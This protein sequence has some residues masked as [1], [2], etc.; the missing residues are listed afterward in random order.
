MKKI[1]LLA[2][3]GDFETLKVAVQAGANAVYLAGKQ[4]GARS[5]SPNFT[6]EELKEA[7]IYAHLRRVKIYITVNTIVYQEEW[8]TLIEYV[9]FLYE[10]GV[11]ALI[12]Q[13]LGVLRYIRSHY[14]DF[15]VHA[16]TQ[17]NIYDPKGAQFLKNVGVKRVVLAREASLE[18]V[19]A[20]VQTGIEVE[21]FVHGAL[22]FASSGNC[23]MSYTIG[24]RSGNRGQCAQPCRKR[25][26][27]LENSH[28]I[29][30]KM[31]LLSMK[32]LNTL[33][34]LKELIQSGACSFKIEGRMK[35]KAYVYCV[36]KNY[37]QALD[38][39]ETGTYDDFSQK[40]STDLYTVFNRQF[41]KGYLLYENNAQLTNVVDVNHQGSYLGK[42]TR[43]RPNEIDILLS[44][45]L[46]VK[47]A[48]RIKGK[49]EVGFILST[50]YVNQEKREIAYPG[51]T[52]RIQMAHK[53]KVGSQVVKTQSSL[54]QQELETQIKEEPIRFPVDAHLFIRLQ[55][56]IS[57]KLS[58]GIHQVIVQGETI[59]ERA[60]QPIAE[61][62]LL[63]KLDKMK[64]TPFVL[65]HCTIDYDQVAFI[66][67]KELNAIRRKATDALNRTILTTQLKVVEPYFEP[68]LDDISHHIQIEAVVHTQEQAKIC[69]TWGITTIYTDYE[70]EHQNY[71]RLH[72]V[73][74]A[75]GLIH[76][77][78]QLA[79][80]KVVSPYLNVVN[81]EAVCF[82]AHF[83][84]RCVYLS[85][86][87]SVDQVCQFQVDQLPIDIGVMIYGRMDVMATQHCMISKIKGY[88]KKQCGACR[89]Q[90]ALADEYGN[91]FPILPDKRHGCSLRILDCHIRNWLR[92]QKKLKLHG[93]HCFLLVF[94]IE[95]EAEVK[96]VLN[97][98]NR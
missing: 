96:Q 15:E 60:K 79:S 76:N 55:Y 40:E 92:Y 28:A 59:E 39:I 88:E 7:I 56:P 86:E 73:Q 49:E 87:L 61:S 66:S 65:R 52:V 33:S 53:Q 6:E 14:P 16:S 20:I 10:I 3:A 13:D 26:T 35:S 74:D 54:L 2:P 9:S 57:L 11:D 24:G 30:K 51:E 93:I 97:Q 90:Y 94:T 43:V 19:H 36:V 34:H 1:E 81:S 12:V 64:D 8:S 89:G 67:I 29:S 37:R 95:T 5:F 38:A 4:F 25:Y 50:F 80:G 68:V 82:L 75:D 22:C 32:D 85:N 45:P 41:T 70:S 71:N 46:C 69:Q 17:M 62:F 42:I 77:L 21:I 63:E 72:I 91:Q 58:D 23:L 48:I 84:M 78:G 47:D 44:A 31:S 98:L 83:G 27:L 18:Q